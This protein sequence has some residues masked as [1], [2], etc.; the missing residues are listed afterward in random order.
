MQTGVASGEPP[1]QHDTGLDAFVPVAHL[2][3]GEPAAH[4]L[5]QLSARFP[6]RV[7][8]LLAAGA[9]PVEVQT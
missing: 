3:D 5:S 2:F 7:Q 1:S 9:L 4:P 6:T 8:D